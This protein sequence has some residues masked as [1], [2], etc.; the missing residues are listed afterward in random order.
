MRAEGHTEMPF[1]LDIRAVTVPGCVDGWMALHERFG[2]LPLDVLLEPAIALAAAG[3]AAS[4]L[5]VG[6]AAR[7]DEGA[8]ANLVELISQL[9]RPGAR[10]RRVG[11]ARTL[12]AIAAGGRAAFYE[13]EFGAGLKTLGNGF[14]ADADLTT[15][16]AEWVTPLT[17][18]AFGVDLWT[19]PPNSQ[20]YLTL[21]ASA[22]A[23]QL[24]LPADPTDPLF[25]HLLIEAATAA[26]FDRPD[27]L[28]HTAD[29]D[30]L[31]RRIAGRLELIDTERASDRWAPA[32]DGDT[33]YLCTVDGNG[34][35]VSL[36]QS[37]AAGFGS[38]LV[39]QS[40]G[41]N[42]HNRGLGFNLLEGH[43]A[44][45]KPG[46]RPPHT[47]CPAMATTDGSLRAVFGTMGGD[48]QP[49]I[50]LQVAARLFHYGQSP[51]AAIDAGRWALQGPS[52]GFD[53]WTSGQAPSVAIEGQAPDDWMTELARRGHKVELRPSYDSGFGHA[54]AIVIDAEG[55]RAAAADPRTMV[56]TAAGI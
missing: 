4:P 2:T 7:T 9:T 28:S 14:Y 41:I 56:G 34:M 23:S 30:E 48:A 33:T 19:I 54:H 10:V 13:G 26:G 15:P 27:A 29:G 37:N 18:Q 1:R 11:V 5:L 6:A 46:H 36:I 8:S 45:L 17:T 39:E 47:L 25:A 40:T 38:G 42:L 22:L 20:G 49:Q 16:I 53:T 51:A 3:F 55:F 31:L 21:G 24:D 52:T 32:R 50:L 44:E 43:P 35:G 12:E